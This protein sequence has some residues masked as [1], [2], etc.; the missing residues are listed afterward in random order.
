MLICYSAIYSIGVYPFHQCA[1]SVLKQSILPFM[2]KRKALIKTLSLLLICYDCMSKI[3]F[4]TAFFIVTGIS[5]LAQKNQ[6]R[7]AIAAFYNCEN[8]FDTVHNPAVKDEEFLPNGDK[9]YTAA[10]YL[11]KLTH[12]ATVISQIGTDVNPDGIAFLGVA[13]IENDTVLS[14]LVHHPLLKNRNYQFIHYDSKDERGID[15]AF[16]YNQKYFTVID[17]KPLLVKLPTNSKNA[18]FTRDVLFVRG[19]LEGEIVNVYVNHWP[20]RLGGEERTA[21]ARAAAAMVNKQ[22]MDSLLKIHPHEKCIIMGDLNDDPVNASLVQVL[23]AKEN[24]ST[25]QANELFNPW[26]EMYKKGLGTLA[27]Q[28]A[29][30]LFD[31]IIISQAWLP[32][33]QNGFFFYQ[34]HI[35][36]KD[37][38]IETNGKYKG[39]PMRT[40]NGNDYRGGYSDHFP[41]YIIFLKKISPSNH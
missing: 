25:L 38:M 33:K 23:K 9:K 2:K 34:P 10:V 32:T 36:K 17:S 12:L 11:D 39:Y 30:G 14:N 41:T 22:H 31:Q 7:I 40:W 28:D 27:Y 35:F 5:V 4:I 18:R 16:I 3:F 20:S 15:V 29:W 6:Y 8:L 24:S 19:K 21:P 13:E 37:F 26:I 1:A